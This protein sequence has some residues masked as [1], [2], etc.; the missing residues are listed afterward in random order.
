MDKIPGKQI[1]NNDIANNI[2]LTSGAV[3]AAAAK[4]AA[5]DLL[6]HMSFE[7]IEFEKDDGSTV[8]IP[9]RYV[10][11]PESGA[12]K[13]YAVIMNGI[14]AEGLIGVS[15]IHVSVERVRR[16]TDIPDM[17]YIKPQHINLYLDGGPGIAQNVEKNEIGP[18]GFYSIDREARDIIFQ[19]VADV[20][21]MADVMPLLMI[22]VFTVAFQN[23]GSVRNGISGAGGYVTPLAQDDIMME[24]ASSLR[25]QY[26]RGIRHIL[27]VPGNS[28]QK[29]VQDQLHISMANS[30][31]CRNYIGVALD[32]AA[33][34]G[35]ENFLLAGNVSKIIR[36][37]AGIMDT[38][39]WIA[40]GRREVLSLHTVLAGGTIAQAR[41]IQD[42][43][44][45]D[46]MLA[47]LTEWGIRDQV[48]A[49]VCTKIADYVRNRIGGN[50]M[51]FGVI[52][53]H[54]EYGIL[55]QTPNISGVLAA[56][57]REQFALSIKK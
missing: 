40:D 43:A 2:T 39:T 47:K 42:L 3:S 15:E 1:L 44:T 51:N 28:G 49:S 50:K 10:P 56:V 5:A 24:I 11:H 36:L 16:L 45:T 8:N 38:H 57:S 27:A 23:A 34:L 17:I 7:N 12:I 48:M 41:I 19:S 30:I 55:G 35:M 14:V 6:L 52:P 54:Q 29:F 20:S 46:Q 25:D 13:E 33:T 32:M 26:E 9:V 31:K 22:K 4:A 37:A 53:V 21:T 18:R